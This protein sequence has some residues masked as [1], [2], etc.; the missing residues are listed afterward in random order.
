M[1]CLE[2]TPS[3]ILTVSL[4]KE[5]TLTQKQPFTAST[6]VKKTIFTFI[7]TKCVNSVLYKVSKSSLS[8]SYHF[9][10]VRTDGRW[11]TDLLISSRLPRSSPPRPGQASATGRAGGKG[12]RT[13][14]RLGPGPARSTSPH[15][16]TL[17]DPG[18]V[19]DSL[20][21]ISSLLDGNSWGYNNNHY[22]GSTAH[23][24]IISLGWNYVALMRPFSPGQPL[25]FLLRHI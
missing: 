2:D 5:S 18:A 6:A 8:G 20:I 7:L 10:C 3:S 15:S 13:K 17:L 16:L 1:Q 9:T 14:G 19:S 22:T 11:E 24:I 21:R 12:S 25:I 23:V 4:F